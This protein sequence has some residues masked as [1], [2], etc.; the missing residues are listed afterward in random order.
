M[1]AATSIQVGHCVEWWRI[2]ATTF[3]ACQQQL[4]HAG[5]CTSHKFGDACLDEI[6]IR[7]RDAE[8]PRAFTQAREVAWPHRQFATMH[9]HGFEDTVAVV[10]GR[11]WIT[12]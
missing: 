7:H 4:E 3:A 1:A 9:A 11:G 8:P 2:A 6:D 10:S 5:I 12:K